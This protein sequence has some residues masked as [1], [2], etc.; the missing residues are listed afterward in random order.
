MSLSPI[1]R[2]PRTQPT[3]NTTK[4]KSSKTAEKGIRKNFRKKAT[5]SAARK[6]AKTKVTKAKIASLN[7]S[8]VFELSQKPIDK[9]ELKKKPTTQIF[10]SRFPGNKPYIIATS[11]YV[12]DFMTATPA[13]QQSQW[14][15][16]HQHNITA[17][18]NSNAQATS[19]KLRTEN[20]LSQLP[21]L[22]ANNETTVIDL[23]DT[24]DETPPRPKLSVNP[25]L[26]PFGQSIV[27]LSSDTQ[28]SN[29]SIHTASIQL[30]PTQEINSDP[31]SPMECTPLI[32]E[33]NPN[34]SEH[35]TSENAKSGTTQESAHWFFFDGECGEHQARIITKN[36]KVLL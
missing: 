30:F 28:E 22:P 17:T 33:T 5:I 12:A 23:V 25:N 31:E 34:T 26:S 24:S 16:N 19:K 13:K 6:T 35:S 15:P 29:P 18:P 7:Q 27:F 21:R 11:S 9:S 8:E 3:K 4:R 20:T 2:L 10:Q 14:S 36:L 1:N 32:P